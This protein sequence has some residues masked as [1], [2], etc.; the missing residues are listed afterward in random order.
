MLDVLIFVAYIVI[1]LVYA[2]RLA[3]RF[4]DQ[5][6]RQHGPKSPFVDRGGLLAVATVLA[7]LWPVVMPL[8]GAYRLL[9]D[10]GLLTTPA[11]REAKERA[12]LK[13]L[14]KQARELGLPMPSNE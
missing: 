10:T 2:W 1:W 8:R 13:A 11:E 5:A 4:I 7:L 9:F 14:R 3:I 12:E 6:I